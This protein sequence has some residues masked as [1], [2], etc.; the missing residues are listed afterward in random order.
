MLRFEETERQVH[1]FLRI[2]AK[3]SVRAAALVSY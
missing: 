3:K 2:R 1:A